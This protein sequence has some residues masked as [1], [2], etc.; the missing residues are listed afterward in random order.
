MILSSS[1]ILYKGKK[2]QADIK[3]FLTEFEGTNDE[4]H[5]YLGNHIEINTNI[6]Q[7][8]QSAYIDQNMEFI[9][10]GGTSNLQYSYDIQLSW[11]TC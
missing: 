2:L 3:Y 8:S 11:R 6:M 4:L 5:W 1:H 9:W 10:T 7:L